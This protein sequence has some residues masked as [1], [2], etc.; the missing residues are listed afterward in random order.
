M[1][2]PTNSATSSVRHSLFRKNGK[3]HRRT[4]QGSSRN[5]DR[6]WAHQAAQSGFLYDERKAE[7]GPRLL[8]GPSAELAEA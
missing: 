1:T 3:G 5:A 8:P 4:R 7:A 2:R 6:Q